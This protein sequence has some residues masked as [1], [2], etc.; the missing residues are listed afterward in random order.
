MSASHNLCAR[1]ISYELAHNRLITQADALHKA[2]GRHTRSLAS[3]YM[4]VDIVY[5]ITR[6]CK[7]RSY[8]T[9]ED[10]SA[11]ANICAHL[12]ARCMSEVH[13]DHVK[14]FRIDQLSKGGKT[15]FIPYT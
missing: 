13:L 1:L 12:Y 7:R 8:F 2:G 5:R 6:Y 3:T 9:S 10:M 11:H 14:T 15:I 4:C